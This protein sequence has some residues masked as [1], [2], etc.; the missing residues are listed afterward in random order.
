V[1]GESQLGVESSSFLRVVRGGRVE[2][3]VAGF[4]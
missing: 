1:P 3:G 4:V 2:L